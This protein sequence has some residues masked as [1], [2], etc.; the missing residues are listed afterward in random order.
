MVLPITEEFHTCKIDQ[1]VNVFIKVLAEWLLPRTLKQ[2][3]R[4]VGNS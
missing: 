3:K 2:R 1:E 4:P